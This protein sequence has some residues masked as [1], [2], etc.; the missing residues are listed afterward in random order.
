MAERGL[1]DSLNHPLFPS[2]IDAR[3]RHVGWFALTI[4]TGL[5]GGLVAAI[6]IAVVVMV[7][8][9]AVMAAGGHMGDAQGV[10]R[11]LAELSQNSHL[12]M[13]W[14]DTITALVL[15]ASANTP[16]FIIPVFIAALVGR[17]SFRLYLTS[18]PRFRWNLMLWAMLLMSGALLP[19]FI[20]GEIIEPTST[21][22]PLLTLAPD[23]PHRLGFTVIAFACLLPAAAAEEVLF[24][25]WLLRQSLA[26]MRNPWAA[27]VLNGILFAA[28]HLNPNLDDSFQLAMMGVSFVYMAYRLGGI[29]FAIGAHAINNILI[30]LFFQPLPLAGAER[31]PF[32]LATLLGGL[33]VPA[34]C[35]AVTEL[36][37][38]WPPL[39][40]LV[41]FETP[42]PVLAAQEAFS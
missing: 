26:F 8:F 23:M 16:A 39:R 4:P 35:L 17:R 10:F 9:V 13:T 3:D 11:R 29:E 41:G 2:A 21:G 32:S 37:V 7:V 42:S 34:A 38:R 18:M 1:L 6:I 40:R 30:V 31:H 19:I 25:G 20:L 14:Q 36:V 33:L 22:I 28:M 15:L 24:R 5:I 27:L 12:P